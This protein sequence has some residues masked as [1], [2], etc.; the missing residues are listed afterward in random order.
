MDSHVGLEGIK[1]CNTRRSLEQTEISSWGT[2]NAREVP[3]PPILVRD[4]AS[5]DLGKLL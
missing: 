1:T 3:K 2:M 5:L 4:G